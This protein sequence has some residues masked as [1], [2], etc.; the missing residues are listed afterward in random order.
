MPIIPGWN[1]SHWITG[2]SAVMPRIVL[3]EDKLGHRTSRL[4]KCTSAA[5]ASVPP[6]CDVD[7][8]LHGRGIIVRGF[9]P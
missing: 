3:A 9:R 8:N 2:N 7:N 1:G 6:G 5:L 4:G